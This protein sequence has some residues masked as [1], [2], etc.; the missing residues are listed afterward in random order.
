MPLVLDEWHELYCV[1]MDQSSCSLKHPDLV[2]VREIGVCDLPFYLRIE[3]SS[4]SY[5]GE[6]V[7][8]YQI[9]RSSYEPD[10]RYFLRFWLWQRPWP[11]TILAETG[12]R[13]VAKCLTG[14]GCC[15]APGVPPAGLSFLLRRQDPVPIL[16][17][18]LKS[19][20]RVQPFVLQTLFM[21][22]LSISAA[23]VISPPVVLAAEEPFTVYTN[24]DRCHPVWF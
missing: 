7:M 17:E 16:P 20:F 4:F 22:F 8:A 19:I 11:A 9:W 5:A 24:C 6:T 1:F 13:V 18:I 15:A 10:F 21:R 12:T 2:M 23:R 14:T 3:R